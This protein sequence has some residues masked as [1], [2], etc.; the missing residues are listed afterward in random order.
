M[1]LVLFLGRYTL[2]TR[3]GYHKDLN[4]SPVATSGATP[5]IWTSLNKQRLTRV[6]Y[7]RRTIQDGYP[8]SVAWV[9]LHITLYGQEN[10]L[11]HFMHSY[12]CFP[13]SFLS[14]HL[15][16]IKHDNIFIT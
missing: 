2:C 7:S 1:W 8:Y 16:F 14:F 5:W 4:S 12:N 9:P 3:V 6:S 10:S 13:F 15:P 11:K